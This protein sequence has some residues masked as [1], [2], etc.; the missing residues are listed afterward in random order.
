[1]RDEIEKILDNISNN[2]EVQWYNDNSFN[3]TNLCEDGVP[4]LLHVEGKFNNDDSL[5]LRL[6]NKYSKNDSEYEYKLRPSW[7]IRDIYNF[8]DKWLPCYFDCSSIRSGDVTQTA[9][10]S[11]KQIIREFE[12]SIIH[13]GYIADTSI[14]GRESLIYRP[15]N[16]AK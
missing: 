15:E 11:L 1:M 5:Q 14:I 8:L 6:L 2:Y 4:N 13:I 10:D 12:K 9:T 7:V 16:I 3:I